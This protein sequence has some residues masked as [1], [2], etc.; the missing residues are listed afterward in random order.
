[1]ASYAVTIGDIDGPRMNTIDDT[2]GYV[3][4]NLTS[5]SVVRIT[6]CYSSIPVD[7][8]VLIYDHGV[9]L[10]NDNNRIKLTSLLL[11]NNI[12]DTL[13]GKVSSLLLRKQTSQFTQRH[14]KFRSIK[15]Q[16]SPST[17][18]ENV[19]TFEPPISKM[20]ELKK[21]YYKMKGDIQSCKLTEEQIHPVFINEYFVMKI[22][23]VRGHMKETDESITSEEEMFDAILHDI[24]NDNEKN[25]QCEKKI[26]KPHNYDFMTPSEKESYAL[27]TG[28]TVDELDKLNV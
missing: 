7:T 6:V 12:Y 1:M 25:K 20:I 17:T 15:K 13:F 19:S 27:Q 3:L 5:Q 23:D 28:T 16:Q 4:T 22:L 26:Y 11:C 9:V 2:L 8:F 10:I 21:T 14:E 24:M 18:E